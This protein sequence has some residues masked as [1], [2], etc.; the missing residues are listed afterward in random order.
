MR[1]SVC[2]GTKNEEEAVEAVIRGIRKA[3]KGAEIVV[4]DSSSDRTPEL[5]EK[6]GARVIRQKPMG[7]GIALKTALLAAKGGVI[8]TTDCDGTYPMEK[9]PEMLALLEKGYDV[10]S[11]SRFLGKSDVKAMPK[12]N[13]FGNRMFAHAANLLYGTKITDITT[14][15]RAFRREVIHSFEWTENVG[16]SLE[17]LFK[18]AR[19]G[20]RIAEIQIDYRERMGQVKLNPIT[21]GMGMAK[22]LLKYRVVGLK[23]KPYERKK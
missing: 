11:A 9:I 2:M 16:L 18:P 3:V 23:R 10:V 13:Q 14:G 8:I 4:V 21:G 1:V 17:L 20:C 5:A 19:A 6:L 12:F 15:M 7:Y 22:T